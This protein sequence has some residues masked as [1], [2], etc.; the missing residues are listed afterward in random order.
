MD[1]IGINNELA[2]QEL[3]AD[4]E[5]G[6][7]RG[8]PGGAPAPA[9]MSNP[10]GSVQP[11]GPVSNLRCSR[12]GFSSLSHC[13]TPS[14]PPDP[15]LDHPVSPVRAAHW[16]VSMSLPTKGLSPR[17]AGGCGGHSM[18][19]PPT[20]RLCCR[21]EPSQPQ[22]GNGRTLH[23]LRAQGPPTALISQTGRRGPG[24]KR[25]RPRCERP[26]H[27]AVLRT[28]GG[29]CHAGSSQNIAHRTMASKGHVKNKPLKRPTSSEVSRYCS[30]LPQAPNAASTQSPV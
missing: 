27:G 13:P 3:K 22:D 21:G 24:W 1:A 7:L 16:A 18:V 14:G 4:A 11:G 25:V 19:P 6:P 26:C 30:C 17:G 2:S 8:L 23:Y 29:V 10:P 28:R 5:A 20:A 15:R 12:H 9:P